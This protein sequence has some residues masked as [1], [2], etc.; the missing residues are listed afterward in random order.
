VFGVK[1]EGK[2]ARFVFLKNR[3]AAAGQLADIFEQTIGEPEPVTPAEAAAD[4]ESAS[5]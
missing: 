1:I 4:P 2:F 3:S 5:P